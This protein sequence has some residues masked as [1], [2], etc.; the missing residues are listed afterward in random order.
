MITF[1][2]YIK[3]NLEDNNGILVVCDVQ[4]EF[5]KFIPSNFVDE[6][7]KYAKKFPTVYQLY[8][9]HIK[10]G[11]NKLQDLYNF[12][13]L[14]G[15]YAKKYGIDFSKDLKNITNE[16]QYA[17]E[18]DKFKV[19]G[20]DA[21]IVKVDNNHKFFYIPEKISELFKSL[22]S[23][24]II[25]CG[26]ADSECLEDCYQA[27]LSYGINVTINKKYIYSAKTNNQQKI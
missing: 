22:S 20:T 13:N 14:K 4:K 11:E 27:M 17:K 9:T 8:D 6:L 1:T 2:N 19:V 24:S 25:L 10:K 16:L 12:P 21:Y 18:G 5:S 3:E 26:G 15:S 7:F 23:K